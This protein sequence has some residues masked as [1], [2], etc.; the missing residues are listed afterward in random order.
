MAQGFDPVKC[1]GLWGG[2]GGSSLTADWLT[3]AGDR[4]GLTLAT[5][6]RQASPFGPANTC[7]PR[8]HFGRHLRL[9]SR[10]YIE[11]GTAPKHRQTL[12]DT[13]KAT[14]FDFDWNDR[15]ALPAIELQ[16]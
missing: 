13:R 14:Y 8:D 9:S 15:R 1:L 10:S 7:S 4:C 2:G 5:P 6:R 3:V 11:H 12:R 16:Q